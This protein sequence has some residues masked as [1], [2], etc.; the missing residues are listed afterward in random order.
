MDKQL[1]EMVG[2]KICHAHKHLE[3]GLFLV[4]IHV[5]IY[6]SFQSNSS[7]PI[8]IDQNT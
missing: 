7:S 6:A 1:S 2:I 4:K 8:S 3:M 5:A